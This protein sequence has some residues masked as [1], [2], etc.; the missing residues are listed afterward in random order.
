M[1]PLKP[2]PFVQSSF[3]MQASP[4]SHTFFFFFSFVYLDMS[5]FPSIFL[6][7]FPLSLC[8]EIRVRR[9]TFFPSEWRFSTL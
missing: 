1:L 8:M 5:P 2:R 7:P 3:D 4:G 6:V 9:S